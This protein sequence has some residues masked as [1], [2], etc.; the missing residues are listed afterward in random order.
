MSAALKPNPAKMS[1]WMRRLNIYI[2]LILVSF[3]V[4]FAPMWLQV[5]QN[6]GALSDAQNQLR[7]AQIQNSLAAS[8]IDARRGDYEPARVATSSFY[9]ALRTEFDRSTDSAYSQPQRDALMP[10]FARRDEIITLLSRNDPASADRLSDVFASY[11][12]SMTP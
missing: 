2:V 12:K 3:L 5:R 7:Q 10:L 6:A 9:T 8:V 1:S 11:T 4:G